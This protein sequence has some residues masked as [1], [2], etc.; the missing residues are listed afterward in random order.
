[1]VENLQQPYKLIFVAIYSSHMDH[2]TW[3]A[4]RGGLTRPNMTYASRKDVLPLQSASNAS[5]F[6][7]MRTW[8]RCHLP[9][10]TL[11][12]YAEVHQLPQSLGQHQCNNPKL[13][14]SP[15]VFVAWGFFPPSSVDHIFNNRLLKLL[16]CQT[17][18]Q[19]FYILHLL[20]GLGR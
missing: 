3:H 10:D 14:P 16:Q 8:R 20:A 1:M 6:I 7:L 5:I 17:A 18:H 2:D 12:I 4:T 9:W 11:P 19:A 15:N 13:T